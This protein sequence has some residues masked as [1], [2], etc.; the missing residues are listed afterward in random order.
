MCVVSKSFPVK[1]EAVIHIVMYSR[2]FPQK[3]R[4]LGAFTIYKKIG[5]ICGKMDILMHYSNY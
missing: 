3:S 5:Q 4:F 2:F 1:S